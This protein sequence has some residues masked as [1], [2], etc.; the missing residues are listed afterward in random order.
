MNN[1]ENIIEVKELEVAYLTEA[2]DIHAVN[3]VSFAIPRGDGRR[4]N[5]NGAEHAPADSRARRDSERRNP[6]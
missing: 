6:V 2:G 1:A 3:N 5:H 4:K